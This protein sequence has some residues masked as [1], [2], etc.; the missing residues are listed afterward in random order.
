MNMEKMLILSS[1]ESF[2]SFVAYFMVGLALFALFTFIYTRVTPYKEF[3]LIR[4]G[5]KAAALCLTGA[6]LGFILPLASVIE[7]SVSL[8]DMAI[9]GGIAL[10]VQLFAFIV[11]R[12]IIPGIA[13]DIAEGKVAQGLFLGSLSLSLG[14]LNAACVTY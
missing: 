10:A 7:E 4:E 5:N 14:I 6:M 11:I 12:F 8:A 2:P 1:F 9:W 13:Q 3:R